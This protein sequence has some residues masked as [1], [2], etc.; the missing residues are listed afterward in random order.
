MYLVRENLHNDGIY[1][2]C[3]DDLLND[4]LVPSHEILLGSSIFATFQINCHML[5]VRAISVKTNKV[6]FVLLFYLFK[7]NHE[8][9]FTQDQK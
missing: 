8:N 3:S 7:I 6:I 4:K 2:N 9:I 1:K 5:I